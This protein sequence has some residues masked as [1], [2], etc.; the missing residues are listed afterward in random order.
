MDRQTRRMF[1]Y[2]ESARALKELEMLVLSSGDK[3]MDAI[4]KHVMNAA[5]TA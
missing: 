3:I 4:T 1:Q 2:E 5:V